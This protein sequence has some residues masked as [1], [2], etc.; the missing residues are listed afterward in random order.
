MEVAAGTSDAAAIDSLMAAAMIGEGTSYASLA[1]T[2]G[3]STE[4][5]GVGFRTGS[6]LAE[7]LNAFLV[8]AYADGTLT[9]L[10]EAYGVQAALIAQE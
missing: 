10:A 2:V 3:L 4:E 9:K 1:Y 8:A 5:Y 6:D 7:K